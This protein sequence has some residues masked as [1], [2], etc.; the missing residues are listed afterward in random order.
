MKKL[1]SSSIVIVSSKGANTHE[2]QY[3]ILIAAYSQTEKEI[4]GE[5]YVRISEEEYKELIEREYVFTAHLNG[6]VVGTILLSKQNETTFSF[7]L[8]A[9]DFSKKGLGIGRKLVSHAEQAALKLGA[10]EM[11]LEILKPKNQHAPFKQQ[12][13]EWYERQ[14]YEYMYSADFLELKPTKI[15]KAKQL[16]TPAVFDCYRKELSYDSLA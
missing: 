6:E 10:K 9:V 12:L 7:G 16:I 8:L 13:A 11:T 4:W 2:E 5:N 3:K 1:L 14:G 15:E